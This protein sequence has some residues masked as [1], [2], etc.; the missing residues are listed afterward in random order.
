[1]NIGP[2][3]LSSQ[4]ILAPMAGITDRPFRQLCRKMGAGLAV[5]E[6]VT[7]K[8]ELWDSKK[9]RSRINHEGE[10]SPVSVQVLGTNP[11]QIA[12]A[13]QFNARHGADI[14]DINMG[15]PAKKVCN[16]SAGSALLKDEKRVAAIL[17]QAVKSVSVPV[18]LKIRTGWDTANRNAVSIASI[19]ESSGIQ[20][21]TIH[22]RTR[23]C[24][25][26]GKAEYDTIASVKQ[27]VGIP[28][29]A[30]GD[31]NSAETAQFVLQYTGADAVMIGRAAKNNPWIFADTNYFLNTGKHLSLPTLQ[32][33][34]TVIV[35]LL[36][37][38]YAFYGDQHG[39][40]IARKHLAWN[41]KPL[42]DG[43]QFWQQINRISDASRQLSMTQE[44][45]MRCL[46]R[47]SAA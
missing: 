21:L 1:M 12:Q 24:G 27:S 18:T 38:L 25:F 13:A 9:T 2:Y 22:G 23:A 14:I 39:V 19:A 46:D 16:V 40:K 3:E 31:I 8:P 26:S 43:E 17:E 35:D 29:I 5:S 41:I 15:C 33:K 37:S 36:K 47:K 34:Y 10:T 28:I 45:F 30:N 44:F 7:S 11:E 42:P 20:A 6:M 32:E 4:T